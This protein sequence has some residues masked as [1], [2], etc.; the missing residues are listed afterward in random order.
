MTVF[1]HS[2]TE[3]GDA[4]GEDDNF[5]WQDG[6]QRLGGQDIGLREERVVQ[7]Q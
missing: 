1:K 4:Q 7:F 2:G 5:W 3:M 6:G